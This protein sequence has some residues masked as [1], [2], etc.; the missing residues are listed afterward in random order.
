MAAVDFCNIIYS[1]KCP[2][3]KAELYLIIK[4]VDV[5]DEEVVH[6]PNYM[7]GLSCKNCNVF[8]CPLHAMDNVLRKVNRN[9]K[10]AINII[11]SNDDKL[12]TIINLLNQIRDNI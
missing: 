1:M 3:C 9:H 10:E 7:K 8:I 2:H 12:T 6:F 4:D 11:E 5:I